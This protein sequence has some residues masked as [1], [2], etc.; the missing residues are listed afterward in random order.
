MTAK[1][2]VDTR[3]MH[4]KLG[5]SFQELGALLGVRNMLAAGL[6]ATSTGSD[7]LNMD[8]AEDKGCHVFDMNYPGQ[9]IG[10]GSVAC[11]GGSMAM[12]MGKNPRNYVSTNGSETKLGPLFWPRNNVVRYRSITQ[13]MAVRAIDNFLNYGDPKWDTIKKS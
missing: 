7:V 11:I 5:I 1:K 10:C 6:M 4:E 13:K 9:V 2:E 8:L 12:L 3:H